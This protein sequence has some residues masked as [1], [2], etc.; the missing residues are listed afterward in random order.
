LVPQ[1]IVVRGIEANEC[2]AID[3]PYGQ[4]V[5]ELR[6]ELA[7]GA[8]V[9]CLRC[10]A[11]LCSAKEFGA[12]IIRPDSKKDGHLGAVCKECALAATND[13]LVRVFEAEWGGRRC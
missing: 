9:A 13:D 11:K 1:T 2:E 4:I 5:A 7:D 12:I 6:D 8:E 10:G 3:E